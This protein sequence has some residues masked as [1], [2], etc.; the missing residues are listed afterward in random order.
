MEEPGCYGAGSHCRPK[1]HSE[2]QDSEGGGRRPSMF[3]LHMMFVQK[4]RQA[5]SCL[6]AHFQLLSQSPVAQTNP[7]ALLPLFDFSPYRLTLVE[8]TVF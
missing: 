2:E 6:G 5:H 8:H 4:D 1:G 3:L 7:A